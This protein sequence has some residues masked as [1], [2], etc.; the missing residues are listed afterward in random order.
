MAD[1]FQWEEKLFLICD[2]CLCRLNV[3]DAAGTC[4][5][6]APCVSHRG[7]TCWSAKKEKV[8]LFLLFL[9]VAEGF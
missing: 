3:N 6:N 4:W 7:G 5:G 9:L 2:F 8:V 1:E